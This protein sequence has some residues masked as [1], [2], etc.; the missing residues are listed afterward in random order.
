MSQE[1]PEALIESGEIRVE[2]DAA[3][4]ARLLSFFDRY[5]PEKAVVVPPAAFS[6]QR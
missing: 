5:V 3:E 1:L 4:V 6:S 2:G